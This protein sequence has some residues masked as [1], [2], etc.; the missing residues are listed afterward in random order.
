MSGG[1]SR[2][3]FDEK[4]RLKKSSLFGEC[5]QVAVERDEEMETNGTS[6]TSQ[7]HARP[8]HRAKFFPRLLSFDCDPIPDPFAFQSCTH[9]LANYPI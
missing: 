5:W 3:D 4:D 8:V 6:G 7:E 1:E 9:N 2:V